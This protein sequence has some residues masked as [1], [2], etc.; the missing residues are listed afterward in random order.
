VVGMR[1]Q[2][3]SRLAAGIAL[4][5]LSIWPTMVRG[6]GSRELYKEALRSVEVQDWPKA[7]NLLRQAITD[8]PNEKAGTFK[9][10]IPHYY[11]GLSLY[12]LGNCKAALTVWADS[13]QQGVITKLKEINTLQQGV[14]VCRKRILR[15]DTNSDLAEV[16]GFAAAL[17]DLR[18][19]PELAESWSSGSPSWNER[20][21]AAERLIAAAQSVLERSDN[22]VT[23]DDLEKAREQVV[24]A[25]QQLEVIQTNARTKFNE[26]QA[27][28][29]VRSRLIEMLLEEAREV[30]SATAYLEP[31]PPRLGQL[32]GQV[33][34]LV[35]EAESL[36]GTVHPDKL[37]D[38]RLSLSKEL[39]RLKQESVPP[40]APLMA[41]ATAFFSAD[42]ARVL[43][44]LAGE[45]FPSG[46]QSAH[47]YLLRAA[48]LFSLWVASGSQ[49]DPTHAAAS[50]AVR[51]CREEDIA[52][53]PLDR[54]FS[55]RFIEFF[56]SEGQSRAPIPLDRE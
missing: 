24:S 26:V 41:A 5:V 34:R 33:Q 31:F 30:L 51:S 18:D 14:G 12:E 39:E 10:Y 4:I 20:F 15:Q 8:D 45:K 53:V 38:L 32:R 49:D 17:G 3:H 48:S 16:Q 23:L 22:E 44:I 1:R 47:A 50:T 11:L 56:F 37:D 28:L 9:K 54:A 2:T 43:E 42:H 52:L 27:K 6:Q 46:R 36:G 35:A 40:P 13:H 29:D 25:A 7:I 21:A 19:Q 55:P